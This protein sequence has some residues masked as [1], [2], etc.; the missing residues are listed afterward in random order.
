MNY[1]ESLEGIQPEHLAGHF[2]NW[3]N[4]PSPEAHL[5]FLQ[6]CDYFCLAIDVP[7]SRGIVW[8]SA[9]SD[10]VSSVFI[11]HL[12]VLPEYQRQGIG[13]ELVRRCLDHYHDIY[14]IDLMCDEDVMS[15][16]ESVGLKLRRS[17]GI[18]SGISID[19]RASRPLRSSS[20]H[21][22]M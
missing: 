12:S 19:N 7:S 11:P 6:G 15:F 3:P 16:Y 4:P 22:S 1:T 21:V 13:K 5:R 20:S 18:V 8:S 17:T 2:M 14:A 10:G 9:I